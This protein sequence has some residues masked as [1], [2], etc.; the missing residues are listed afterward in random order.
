MDT[1]D[2]TLLAAADILQAATKSISY[3]VG[4]KKRPRR[5]PFILLTNSQSVVEPEALRLPG[6]P[7][8]GKA[9]FEKAILALVRQTEQIS[10]F[11]H[12][13]P[14]TPSYEAPPTKI[15]CMGASPPLDRSA[16]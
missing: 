13:G 2:E 12:P 10:S 1:T 5:R 6:Q 11:Y 15:I 16:Q 3:S 9:T 7:S 8:T 14:I 4:T